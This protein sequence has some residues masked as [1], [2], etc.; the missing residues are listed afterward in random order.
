[1]LDE[2]FYDSS[3]R[4]F[5]GSRFFYGTFYQD[6]RINNCHKNRSGGVFILQGSDHEQKRDSLKPFHIEKTRGTLALSDIIRR[7]PTRA[8]SIHK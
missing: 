1:M 5:N 6:K 8:R 4:L 2:I 3:Q 7:F